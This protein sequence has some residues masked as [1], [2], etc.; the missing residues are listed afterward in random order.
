[1]PGSAPGG[2]LAL[3]R[4]RPNELASPPLLALDAAA[5]TVEGDADADAM[6]E[7]EMGGAGEDRDDAST[8]LAE[9]PPPLK[10]VKEEQ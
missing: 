1:M 4:T 6:P 2:A 10:D 8:P 7:V 3:S 5:S 9:L